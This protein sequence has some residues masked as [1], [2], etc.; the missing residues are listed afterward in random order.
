LRRQLVEME[1]GQRYLTLSRTVRG[2]AAPWG[3]GRAEFAIGLGCDA[4]HAASLAWAAGIDLGGPAVPI[5]PGCAACH[6]ASCRQR[7]LP[8]AGARLAFDERQ[9]GLTPFRFT[10]E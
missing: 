10:D 7:S 4:R 9:R 3:S 1:D 8:P 2:T 6:R 5:G